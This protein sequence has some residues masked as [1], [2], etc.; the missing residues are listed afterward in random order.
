MRRGQEC[1]SGGKPREAAADLVEVQ[2]AG[3][4]DEIDAAKLGEGADL[5]LS[6]IGTVDL[7][8]LFGAANADQGLEPDAVGDD[9][10]AGADNNE[11]FYAVY[12]FHHRNRI[13]RIDDRA[14]HSLEANIAFGRGNAADIHVALGFGQVDRS[15][16]VRDNCT[17]VALVE[18]AACRGQRAGDVD[19]EIVAVDADAA[20][21]GAERNMARHDLGPVPANGVDDRAFVRDEEYVTLL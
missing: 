19:F 12:D 21:D 7:Q 2:I 17:E 11:S 18:S 5:A 20:I 6:L 13:F 8:F 10:D 9:V 14:D 15:L 1:E 16:G 4:F 3:G